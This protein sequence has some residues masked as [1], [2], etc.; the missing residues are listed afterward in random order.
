MK[1]AVLFFNTCLLT[2]IS[3]STTAFAQ[4]AKVKNKKEDQAVRAEINTLV[5]RI[6][7]LSTQ[8]GPGNKINIQVHQYNHDMSPLAAEGLPAK[9]QTHRMPVLPSLKAGIGIIMSPNT[10][11]N[12]VLVSAVTP[13]GPAAKAGIRS[14]DVLI[15]INTTP[16]NASGAEGLAKARLALGKLVVNQSVPVTYARSGKTGRTTITA[17]TISRAVMFSGNDGSVRPIPGSSQ[18]NIFMHSFSSED[19]KALDEVLAFTDCERS[20]KQIC[21][22]PPFFEAMRWQGLNLASIDAELGRYFGTSQGAL[23]INA[24]P[25]LSVIQSG[26]VIQ[27]IDDN[28]TVSPREVMS[29][30]REKK[31]GDVVKFTLLRNRQL[32]T[33]NVKAPQ[34]K[35]LDFMTPPMPPMPPSPPSP[36]SAPK[37]PAPP[38]HPTPPS[39]PS[40]PK[41]PPATPPTFG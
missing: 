2:A 1:P 35:P 26:D 39:A 22:T 18:K 4:D 23:V 8:L 12:G 38:S 37:P 17:S 16:I 13:N 3:L 29:Q 19:R 14:G 40:P 31:Y 33:L 24:G 6:R 27:K 36:S 30:L 9:I 7:Q 41:A 32:L 15:T 11:A 5:E 21:P 10:A 20:G 34:T 28:S 25:E